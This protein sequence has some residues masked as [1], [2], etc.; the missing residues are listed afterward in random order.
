LQSIA[1]FSSTRIQRCGRLK[2]TEFQVSGRWFGNDVLQREVIESFGKIVAA[3]PR[4]WN[5]K[6][7]S[8]L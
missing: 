6:P 4:L 5:P 3:A 1:K 2:R 7:L 8:V